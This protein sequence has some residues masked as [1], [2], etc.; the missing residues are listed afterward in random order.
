MQA[1]AVVGALAVFLFLVPLSGKAL[2]AKRVEVNL[3]NQTLQTYNDNQLIYNFA[4]STG[5]PGTPTPTGTF[6]PWSK[7]LSTKMVGGDKQLGTYYNLPNVPYVVYFYQ[8]Y[9]IHGTYWHN[10]F[11]VPMSH[12]CIN[13]RTDQARLVYNW[14]EMDT[15]ITIY[16]STPPK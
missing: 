10:N 11:G 9:G 1:K 12:G 2:A 13:M 6:K 16:G 3:S 4:V 8:S 15:P 7:L 5:N 14:I